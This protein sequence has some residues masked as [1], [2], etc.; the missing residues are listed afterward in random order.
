MLVDLQCKFPVDRH[1]VH[2]RIPQMAV[3]GYAECGASIY[4]YEMMACDF[5]KPQL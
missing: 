5:V 3:V 1:C 2:P 4:P